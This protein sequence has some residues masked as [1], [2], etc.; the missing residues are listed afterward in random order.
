[1]GDVVNPIPYYLMRLAPVSFFGPVEFI[2]VPEVV[3]IAPDH[4]VTPVF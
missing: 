4:Y 2:K 1:M 3:Y